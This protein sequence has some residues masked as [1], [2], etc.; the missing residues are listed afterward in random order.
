MASTLQPPQQK[1]HGHPSGRMGPADSRDK[2]TWK[3]TADAH[4]G[5]QCVSC[6]LH[7]TIQDARPHRGT[8]GVTVQ[9]NDVAHG[10]ARGGPQEPRVAAAVHTWR[11]GPSTGCSLIGRTQRRAQDSLPAPSFG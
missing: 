10:C 7:Q 9:E 5:P 3:T 6:P 1:A 2:R 11:E 8:R 4:L